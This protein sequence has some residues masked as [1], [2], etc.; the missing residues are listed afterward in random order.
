MFVAANSID[1]CSGSDHA[2][3]LMQPRVVKEF[4]RNGT[5]QIE[6][7]ETIFPNS[8]GSLSRKGFLGGLVV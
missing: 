8:L 2:D 3:M 6:H 4:E 1:V 5:R 7:E